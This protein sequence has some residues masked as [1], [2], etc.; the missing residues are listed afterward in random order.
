MWV[1]D[2]SLD[3]A[4]ILTSDRISQK[5]CRE[6]AGWKTLYHRNVLPLLGVRIISERRFVMVLKWMKNGNIRVFL[7]ANPSVDRLKLVSSSFR[8]LIFVSLFVTDVTI[9]VAS[10]RRRGVDLYA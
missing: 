10:R 6:V 1:P 8:V 3:F 9:T 2:G 5:F 4:C 7:E